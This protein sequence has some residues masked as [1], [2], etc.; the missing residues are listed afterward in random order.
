MAP[1]GAVSHVLMMSFSFKRSFKRSPHSSTSLVGL[2]GEGQ[3][4]LGSQLQILWILFHFN[5]YIYTWIT[6]NLYVFL[7]FLLTVGSL[8]L[9]Y[10]GHGL[11]GF[12]LLTIGGSMGFEYEHVPATS[13]DPRVPEL[14]GAGAP[15]TP[16]REVLALWAPLVGVWYL[17]C[18]S[19]CSISWGT[20]LNGELKIPG[21]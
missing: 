19:S 14:L 15:S 8:S 4:R 9:V 3:A 20:R 5:M 13:G 18:L 1:R 16:E 17:T 10:H 21:R 11:A 6:P 12:S 2:E 7:D